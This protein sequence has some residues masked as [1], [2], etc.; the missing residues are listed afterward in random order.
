MHTNL[1]RIKL[2]KQKVN[3]ILSRGEGRKG[4]S[5][6]LILKEMQLVNS[7]QQMNKEKI[8]ALNLEYDSLIESNLNIS[9]VVAELED[10]K[11]FEERTVDLVR[12]RLIGLNY[13]MELLNQTLDSI[14][15]MSE[16]NSGVIELQAADLKTAYY[17]IGDFKTLSAQHIVE[18]RGGVAGLGSIPVILKDFDKSKFT[19]V[20]VNLI[21]E[22]ELTTVKVELLSTHPSGS[23]KILD[24]GKQKVISIINPQQFWGTTHYLIVLEK[25]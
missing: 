12:D 7:L 4:E 18:K 6:A 17:C 2:S 20:D 5:K 8:A 14:A 23:Y 13:E 24:N 16:I 1:A 22:I 19:T 10:S 3:Q 21:Q 9:K 25:R 11:N 15:F